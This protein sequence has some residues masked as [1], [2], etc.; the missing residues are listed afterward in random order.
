MKANNPIKIKLYQI[1]AILIILNISVSKLKADIYEGSLIVSEYGRGT[2]IGLLPGNQSCWFFNLPSFDPWQTGQIDFDNSGNSYFRNHYTVNSGPGIWKFNPQCNVSA[3]PFNTNTYSNPYT[4]SEYL[5]CIDDSNNV[6]NEID[7]AIYKFNSLGDSVAAYYPSGLQYFMD[8]NTS[9]GILYY[10]SGSVIKRFNV[11]QNYQMS[12]LNINQ[13]SSGLKIRYNGEIFINGGDRIIRYDTAGNLLQTYN[14]S[15]KWNCFDLDSYENA[16]WT[17]NSQNDSMFVNR[18]SISDGSVLF[19][20]NVYM[21]YTPDFYM[22]RVYKKQSKI[23]SVPSFSIQGPDTICSQSGAVDYIGPD[24]VIGCFKYKWTVTG[25]AAITGSDSNRMVSIIH[26]S[27]G[28]YH[29]DCK[30]LLSDRTDSI[31]NGLDVYIM[32][33]ISGPSAICPYGGHLYNYSSNILGDSYLW[34]V[35]PY[36]TEPPHYY[37][38]NILGANNGNSVVIQPVPLLVSGVFELRLRVI[39]NT[40]TITCG[41]FIGPYTEFDTSLITGADTLKEF[42]TYQYYSNDNLFTSNIPSWNIPVPNG[43]QVNS[44]LT[45]GGYGIKLTYFRSSIG[46]GVDSLLKVYTSNVYEDYNCSF[47][48]L[49]GIKNARFIS[50]QLPVSLHSATPAYGNSTTVFG[51]TNLSFNANVTSGSQIRAYFYNTKPDTIGGLPVGIN[52]VSDYNWIFFDVGNTLQFTNGIVSVPVSILGNAN[53]DSLN[54]LIRKQSSSKWINA[55]GSVNSGKF[56]STIP[57]DSLFQLAIG[58]T[59]TNLIYSELYNGNFSFGN[60]GFTTT[61][62]FC[63]T[64][65]CMVDENTY[66]IGSNANFFLNIFQGTDHTTGTGNFMIVNGSVTSSH[67][68]WKQSIGVTQ[69]TEYNFSAWFC[70]VLNTSPAVI[71]IKINGVFL[72]NPFS[73]PGSVNNWTQM[74]VVWN[75][76]LNTTADI[77]I[78]EISNAYVGNDFGMDDISF[79]PVLPIPLA[80]KYHGGSG[81]GYS[82][83]KH[84]TEEVYQLAV[85]T[86]GY[87]NIN[88]VG[89]SNSQNITLTFR[90]KMNTASFNSTNIKVYGSK[91]GYKTS[92]ITFDSVTKTLTINPNNDFKAGEKVDVTLKKG[93]LSTTNDTLKPFQY[94]YTVGVT[95][96]DSV[97]SAVNLSF[98]NTISASGDVDNDND[99]DIITFDG[100]TSPPKFKVYKNNGTGSFSPASEFII[101]T[102]YPFLFIYLTL[103]DADSDGD[104]D[105]FVTTEGLAATMYVV[106]NDG[107]GA[108]PMSG[109]SYFYHTI[110]PVTKLMF[111]DMNNDGDKDIILNSMGL[112]ILANNGSG[113]FDEIHDIS[114]LGSDIIAIGEIIPALEG[115]Y[116]ILV[117]KLDNGYTK[118]IAYKNTWNYSFTKFK[119]FDSI[120]QGTYSYDFGLVEDFTKDMN[121]DVIVSQFPP[122]GT[123]KSKLIRGSIFFTSSFQSISE[124]VIN[125]MADFD[126]DSDLDFIFTNSANQLALYKGKNSS[127]M[128]YGI[129][130]NTLGAS[131]GKYSSGDFDNDGDID[132]LSGNKLYLNGYVPQI[133]PLVT[134]LSPLQNAINADKSSDITAEF[135]T[136]MDSSTINSSNIRVIGSQTGSMNCVISYDAVLKKATINPNNDFKTGEEI[137]VTLKSGIMNSSGLA[138]ESHEFKFTVAATQGSGLFSET[139]SLTDTNMIITTGDVDGDGDIDFVGTFQNFFP[140]ITGFRVYKNNGSGMFNVSSVIATSYQWDENTQFLVKLSDI[141]NDGDLDLVGEKDGIGSH[142]Y[143]EF[144]DGSG[145]FGGGSIITFIEP[146]QEIKL[147]DFDNDG[148]LD[149]ATINYGQGLKFS[150]NNGIG[151]FHDTITGIQCN[152][153]INYDDYDND[154][155]IDLILM[156]GTTLKLFSNN[157]NFLFTETSQLPSVTSKIISSDIDE[158]GDI[159]LIYSN[160]DAYLNQGNGIFIIRANVS[161]YPHFIADFD[162]DGDLD[163]VADNS[164]PN[165]IS[166][167][168]NVGYGIFGYFSKIC[169]K[170]N[171][172]ELLPGDYDG[173]GDIDILFGGINGVHVLFNFP[174]IPTAQATAAPLVGTNSTTFGTTNLTFA[175]NVSIS[176][177]LTVSFYNIS[178]PQSGLPSG[179]VSVGNNFWSVENNNG[180]IFSNGQMSI[181]L[182]LL[183]GADPTTI[184]WLKRSNPGDPWTDIGGSISGSNFISTIPFNTFSEFVLGNLNQ[185]T[186]PVT[187]NVKLLLEGYY[188][189]NI[190]FHDSRDTFTVVLRNAIAPFAAVDSAESII[191]PQTF[192]GSFTFNNAPSGTYYLQLLS[193]NGIETWSKSGGEIYT[194]GATLNYDFTTS[195]SRAYGNNL[196]LKGEKYCIYSGDINQDAVID[197]SDVLMVDNDAAN[198]VTGYVNSDVDGDGFVDGN[199]L[200][201][202]DNNAAIFVSVVN[203]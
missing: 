12:D 200:A 133:L 68:F 178:P 124:S 100:S 182:S 75:S 120:P 151:Q 35:M 30:V 145:N 3:F 60:T 175:G 21:S 173:D 131:G 10:S 9:L 13:N 189:P 144:N 111:A 132:I 135:N 181:P 33:L 19:N 130:S 203:P 187:C 94:N 119:T 139:I 195:Y 1:L 17:L 126:N 199:D 79:T 16:F 148:D 137:S 92:V 98:V 40:D 164:S 201:I 24:D 38:A 147:G 169:D 155:K 197:G 41:K 188:H 59:N 85:I 142:L 190:Q 134:N 136:D 186:L 93:I 63:N 54:W 15:S 202:V 20:W 39:K 159:D 125:G 183:G 154:G 76:L 152:E 71:Q 121:T 55:G 58:F 72:G 90:D 96:G 184:T 65:N 77:E 44:V 128:P 61:Y 56:N 118:A 122:N 140:G 102:G 81:D 113:N 101:G 185:S 7:G 53:L 115:I 8:I 69:N 165:E 29:L 87:P 163:L 167:F 198:F 153:V 51:T 36:T 62:S 172:S 114:L 31:N 103:E 160:G 104:L 78:Y 193:K 138:L 5:L 52:K 32:N 34:E 83:A 18:V 150:I 66:G 11:R 149:I 191:D 176:A 23:C 146:L 177:P 117:S 89:V 74:N 47:V 49:Q 28:N 84:G 73:L 45:N 192:T 95:S 157:G 43:Y 67:Y 64:Q 123:S 109:Y 168:K 48:S 27:T 2:S 97:F 170:L 179:V 158:D 6:Y 22:L 116:D 108:F 161:L 171:S 180:V 174:Q 143:S 70:S 166:L 105:V 110:E 99:L 86:G 57:V 91:S 196:V 107:T 112:K 88:E 80:D 127:S 141:D 37:L 4:G 26:D 82:S 156:V 46:S 106:P 25:N 162:S 42:K 50:G 14:I 129:F 194:R